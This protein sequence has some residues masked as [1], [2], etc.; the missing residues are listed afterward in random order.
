MKR[1]ILVKT[2]NDD[3]SNEFITNCIYITTNEF[4][5][6]SYLFNE[7]QIKI[8]IYNDKIQMISK[9]E[10]ETIIILSS[11]PS[12][13]NKNKYGNF[14]IELLNHIYE[15]DDKKIYISYNIDNGSYLSKHQL[16]IEFLS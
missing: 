15:V 7:Y 3:E 11:N 10:S 14:E 1:N 2:I 9:G 12:C 16:I 8:S 5:E 13:I 6:L 4:K